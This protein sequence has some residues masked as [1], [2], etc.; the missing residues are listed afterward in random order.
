ME[1]F[2]CPK[3]PATVAIETNYYCNGKCFFCNSVASDRKPGR[4]A[5]PLFHKIIDEISS[6]NVPITIS[7]N[8]YGEPF[9][10]PDWLHLFEYIRDTAPMCKISVVTN[11]SA[12]D[13]EKLDHLMSFRNISS[14][15]FSVYAIRPENYQRIMGLPAET[16][17]KV[18]HAIKR[19]SEERPDIPIGVAC[20]FDP[21]YMSVQE[22]GEMIEKWPGYVQPHPMVYTYQHRNYKQIFTPNVPCQQPFCSLPIYH[23]GRVPL[24]CFDAEGEVI[25]GDVNEQT[26]YEIWCGNEL[27]DCRALHLNLERGLIP[28]CNGCNYPFNAIQLVGLNHSR[29][30]NI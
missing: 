18:D 16:I 5:V 28:L 4:M 21:G 1:L 14:F 9:L 19:F 23:D 17:D 3:Y 13:D 20:T 10:N 11:G 24:C 6:W 30:K 26:V 2:S 8:V 29:G 15:G 25:V 22:K 7:L 12:I 27:H